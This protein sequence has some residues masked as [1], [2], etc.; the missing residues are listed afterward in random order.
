[1]KS[2]VLSCLLFA[3]VLASAD[4]IDLSSSCPPANCFYNFGYGTN[5]YGSADFPQIDGDPS[6][7]F[8]TADPLRYGLDDQGRYYAYFGY[9]GTF[10]ITY[11]D[12]TFSGV[13][14]SGEAFSNGGGMTSLDVDFFGQWSNGQYGRGE[15]DFIDSGGGNYPV[16]FTEG[17]VNVPEPGTIAL[18]SGGLL[19]LARK[20]LRLF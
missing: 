10:G 4:N 8:S 18:L 3:S 6:F 14:T 5:G 17:E 19:V 1:M 7:M 13:V 11:G 15:A 9:G 20:R 16:T 12:L 2:W